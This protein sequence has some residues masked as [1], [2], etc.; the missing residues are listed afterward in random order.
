MS[1]RRLILAALACGLAILVAGTVQL[2]RLRG[3]ENA[4][5]RVLELGAAAQIGNLRVTARSAGEVDGKDLLAVTYVADS[6]AVDLGDGSW[7]VQVG[8]RRSNPVAAPAS[9]NGLRSCA[10]VAT[11]QEGQPVECRLAFDPAD[12]TRYLRFSLAGSIATWV[13]EG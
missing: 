1:T 4:T 3:S 6:A 12:G 9:D 8:D 5:A 13:V 11:V 7:T 2:L 10:D